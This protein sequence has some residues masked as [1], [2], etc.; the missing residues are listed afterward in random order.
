M[1]VSVTADRAVLATGA[2]FAHD[3]TPAASASGIST[4]SIV[5]VPT[6]RSSDAG[7]LAD[8]PSLILKPGE[9]G[10][11]CFVLSRKTLPDGRAVVKIAVSH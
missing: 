4:V 1:V 9:P 8:L 10:R 11:D 6:A 7:R 5:W 3:D 2:F